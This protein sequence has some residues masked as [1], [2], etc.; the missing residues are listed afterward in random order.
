[1]SDR[2]PD[3][4]PSLLSLPN[5]TRLRTGIGVLALLAFLTPLFAGRAAAFGTTDFPCPASLEKRVDFWVKIFAEVSHDERVLHDSRY[6]WIIY[7]TIAVPD[8]DQDAIK[9]RL[10]DRKAHYKQVLES[11]AIKDPAEY[12]AEESR[13]AALFADSDE[14]APFTRAKERVRSQPGVKEAMRDGIVRAGRYRDWIAARLDSLDVPMEVSFLPYLESSF[15]PAA[16]SKVGAVGLWQFTQDTGRRYMRVEDDLDERLDPFTATDAAASYLKSARSNLDSWPLAIVS[17]NHGVSGI[18]RAIASLGTT[19]IARII[20]EYDG[21]SFGFASQNFYCEF[22]AVTEIGSHPDHYFGQV[23][24]EPRIL[25]DEY[26]LPQYAKVGTLADAFGLTRAELAAFNPAL[27]QSY[28]QDSRL[29]PKGYCLRLPMGRC[30]DLDAAF[31]SIPDQERFNERPR[32]QGYRV[33]RG[34]TLAMIAKRHRVSV[35]T[36]RKMNNIGPR[37]YI[38]PGQV[39]I[40]PDASH[41]TR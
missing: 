37:A 29:V 41:P 22:L 19:D 14:L 36:I 17:Y 2:R 31:A 32:P 13:V 20:H 1:M 33:R 15:H 18:A 8:L 39:L 12:S 9:K 35:D 30:G 11:L 21:P 3:R 38:K 27:G 10:D 40:L 4:S 34:D 23:D 16:R 25:F 26:P 24:I 7:E 6:P 28:V 5:L